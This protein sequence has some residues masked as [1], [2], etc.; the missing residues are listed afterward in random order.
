MSCLELSDEQVFNVVEPMVNDA[1]LAANRRDYQAHCSL[2]SVDLKSVI[3]SDVFLQRC[4]SHRKKWGNAGERV[5]VCT[6]RKEK[7]FTVIW[8]QQFDATED[9]VALL[10]TV[11]LKGGRYFIDEF[12]LI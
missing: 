7:S 5:F 6:F 2:F 9:Q 10:V 12:L 4:E 3:S 1:M 8:N 11:A